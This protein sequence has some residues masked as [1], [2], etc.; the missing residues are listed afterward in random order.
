MNGK[1][2][3]AIGATSP[4]VLITAGADLGQLLVLAGIAAGAALG[5]DIDHPNATA[6]RALGTAVHK[7]VHTLSK[8]VRWA[9]STRADRAAAAQ[10]E[11]LGRDADHRALTHTGVSALVVGTAGFFLSLIPFGSV[12]VVALGG[13]LVGNLVK[14]TTAPVVCIA[15]TGLA[16]MCSVPAWMAASAVALGWLSHVLAD[17]CTMGGVPLMW[18]MRR[19]GKRWKH[20]RFLGKMLRSGASSEWAV[21]MGF[22]VVLSFPFT[23]VMLTPYR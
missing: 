12:A 8:T 10:W 3:A 4:L 1:A 2:H 15:L 13:W 21:A 11:S 23:V 19:D 7:S 18:P 17:A 20:T 9:T 14:R 5:P 6:T 16:V 22:I